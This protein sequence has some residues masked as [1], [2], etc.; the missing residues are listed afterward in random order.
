MD[1][2]V[3]L[4]RLLSL[5]PSRPW[6]SGQELASRMDVSS[7][8][9]RRDVTRL[10]ELGYPVQASGGH[11]GGYTLG[12][13]GRLPP[14]LLD[15]DEA[16][17]TTVGL[18][19]TA[20]S[21]VAGIETAAVAALAKLGQVLPSRLR[22]RVRALQEATVQLA[23]EPVLPAVDPTVLTALATACWRTEALRFS[24]TDHA[25]RISVRIV[26]PY[27][28]VRAGGRWYLVAR[29]RD[30][31]AWRTFRIDR[32]A[33]PA[34]TGHRQQITDP[35][36]AASMVLEATKLAVFRYEARILLDVE[37]ETA[38]QA[39]RG[40]I[41][42]PAPDGRAILRVAANDLAGLA[43]YAAGLSYDFEV[44]DP[45]ELRAELRGRALE[46]AARHAAA[47]SSTSA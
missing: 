9:L 38:V 6:W 21:A 26:E 44:L 15:D 24:Y 18:Q 12:A 42:E 28:V 4:L 45:P 29:D 32:I 30:R 39:F 46:I 7:R 33:E 31:Q 10:R 17:A 35:P 16:V 25:G 43:S 1:P 5:L 34:L 13:G 36:D 22:E 41:V 47:R 2:A 11:A 19:M 8:T 14:L 3:R 27:Q 20:A 37:Y 40:R 23:A